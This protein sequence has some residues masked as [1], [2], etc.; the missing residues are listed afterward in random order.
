MLVNAFI[1][2]EVYAMVFIPD[3][4]LEVDV[5]VIDIGETITVDV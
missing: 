5:D 1:D 4:A 3:K 2:V